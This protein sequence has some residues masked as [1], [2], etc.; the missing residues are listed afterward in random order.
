MLIHIYIYTYTYKYI[1]IYIYIYIYKNVYIYKWV[2][3]CFMR[4]TAWKK[5]KYKG[6]L[7]CLYHVYI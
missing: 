4:L 5:I 1:Y 3:Y 2:S 7:H 6:I